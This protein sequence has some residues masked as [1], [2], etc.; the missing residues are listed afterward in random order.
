M[1][2]IP[3]TIK[4]DRRWK[5]EEINKHDS[6]FFRRVIFVVHCRD[7]IKRMDVRV[8]SLSWKAMH[9]YDLRNP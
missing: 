1:S 2:P 5:V 9:F 4:A 6:D 8:K 7:G 3:K